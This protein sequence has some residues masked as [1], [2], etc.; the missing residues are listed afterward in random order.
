MIIAIDLDDTL[1]DPSQK[2]PGG[3]MGKPFE[4]TA[5]ALQEFLDAGYEIVVFSVWADDE[6][7]IATIA[8]WM[9][10]FKLPYHKITNIKPDAEYFIDDRAV[11]F[12]NWHD[13]TKEIRAREAISRE[14]V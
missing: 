8:K 4:G 14:N 7:N 6:K 13:V 2:P 9:E 11:R 1:H 3:R 5:E 12:T 10:Y